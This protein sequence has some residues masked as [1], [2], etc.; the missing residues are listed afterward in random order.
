MSR[1]LVYLFF[2][3]ALVRSFLPC[4]DILPEPLKLKNL[5]QQEL[6][7]LPRVGP[8]LAKKLGQLKEGQSL[9][10]IDGI[11]PVLNERLQAYILLPT[12]VE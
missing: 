1:A 2:L 11:G 7:L 12:V 6:E 3:F 5:S 4:T 9:D 8:A 10:S